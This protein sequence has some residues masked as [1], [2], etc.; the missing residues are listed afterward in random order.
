MSKLETSPDMKSQK[1]LGV[2][3]IIAM[4]VI[5]LVLGTGFFQSWQEA[6]FNPNQ[7]ARLQ[8]SAEG[9]PELV[10]N[11]NRWGHYVANGHINDQPVV[12]ILD[13]GASD[14]SIPAAVADRLG[15]KRGPELTY[16]TANGPAR[17]FATQLDK[18]DLGGIT[19]TNIRAS[20][21]PNMHDDEVLLGMTFLR[22]LEFTQRGDTLTLRQY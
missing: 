8:R 7:A 5:I 3:M 10:L 12:F 9:I 17:M 13:T 14:V 15:L 11:R 2:G 16:M 19:L 18:V 4:W 1:R 21:N 20:I 22:H 6:E